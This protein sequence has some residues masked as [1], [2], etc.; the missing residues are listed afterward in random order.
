[1]SR[2]ITMDQ[3]RTDAGSMVE[4]I[5]DVIIAYKEFDLKVEE[6]VCLKI[7]ALLHGEGES[8]RT[9]H[10]LLIIMVGGLNVSL[11]YSSD[12]HRMRYVYDRYL[13]CWHIFARLHFPNQPKRVDDILNCLGMVRFQNL[14]R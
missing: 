14:S 8:C 13:R 9:V 7:V 11:F 6:Y 4:K 12:D 5:T 2:P 1:M 10:L 3:L